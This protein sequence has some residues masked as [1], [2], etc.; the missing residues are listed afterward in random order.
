MV[1]AWTCNS[2]SW[3][4]SAIVFTKNEFLNYCSVWALG[5]ITLLVLL[6]VEQ[7]LRIHG[8][9]VFR[10]NVSCLFFGG[11][12]KVSVGRAG[13]DPLTVLYIHFSLWSRCLLSN[14]SR[15]R[16]KCVVLIQLNTLKH[17][18]TQICAPWC[19]LSNAYG[20]HHKSPTVSS[21]GAA[22]S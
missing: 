16:I 12:K 1:S 11:Q 13:I 20:T 7:N 19:V 22:V 21:Y 14:V 10:F 15:L 2:F 4:Q 6:V 8:G 17:V 5:T 3:F 18:H 9:E